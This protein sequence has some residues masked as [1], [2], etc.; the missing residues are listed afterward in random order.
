MIQILT[1]H[2]SGTGCLGLWT[3]YDLFLKL[4]YFRLIK[5]AFLFW[6]TKVFVLDQLHF[7]PSMD[8]MYRIHLQQNSNKSPQIRLSF[9]I[10]VFLVR[11][12]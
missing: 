7:A 4:T 1:L 8:I 11:G 6:K 12:V 5:A 2:F 10:Y 9:D 3:H